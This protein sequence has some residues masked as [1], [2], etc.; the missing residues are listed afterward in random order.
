MKEIPLK[1]RKKEIVAHA[2]V[3][4]ED[5]D[6]LISFGKWYAGKTYP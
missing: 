1:N 4:D 5:F 3:S 6:F 2:Q